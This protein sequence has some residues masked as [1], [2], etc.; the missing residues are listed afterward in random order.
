MTAEEITAWSSVIT[1]FVTAAG[2]GV[3]WV[4]LSGI[5]KGLNMS[6]LMAVLEIETQM[7][8]RKV[9]FDLCSSAVCT[10]KL[11]DESEDALRIHADL[12]DCAKESYFNALD[13]LCFCVLRNYVSDKDWRAEYRNLIKRV[14][15]TYTGDFSEASPFHNIKK[16][17]SRWQSE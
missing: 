16:L 4:Q 10:A 6:S 7:N 8:E 13:R 11:K 14:I 9:H 2:I 3:A 5:K 12:F 17:N 1:V 15:D